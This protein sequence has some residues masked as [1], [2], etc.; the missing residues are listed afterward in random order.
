[1]SGLAG[2]PRRDDAG[3]LRTSRHIEVRCTGKELAR[4]R[5]AVEE[6]LFLL[7]AGP[8][9]NQPGFDAL[10]SAGLITR[11]ER[12]RALALGNPR[13]AA[14]P[15]PGGLLPWMLLAGVIDHE[16]IE[17]I[18]T[19]RA[20]RRGAARGALLAEARERLR[21]QAAEAMA[22]PPRPAPEHGRPLGWRGRV[23]LLIFGGAFVAA[24]AGIV[25]LATADPL[26]ACDDP[27]V[28]DAVRE[29]LA[30]DDLYPPRAGR[31]GPALGEIAQL[32]RAGYARYPSN[33]RLRVC[34]AA[35]HFAATAAPADRAWQ[36][37]YTFR[38]ER[39]PYAWIG[40]TLSDIDKPAV[41]REP[42][43]R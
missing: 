14:A 17:Q 18:M 37:S 1:V 9:V 43:R 31:G 23:A 24:L 40:F 6:A 7:S 39:T 35:I 2:P 21:V 12:N 25:D 36:G 38:I 29:R 5:A 16:R 28:A 8:N 13:K 34:R 30:E 19:G 4:L 26:P 42:P 10:V 15:T 22:G 32:Y 11:S 27:V 41:T 3:L 33:T 20:G